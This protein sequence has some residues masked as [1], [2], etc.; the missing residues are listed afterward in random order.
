[1]L[2]FVP[3][4]GAREDDGL[5]VGLAEL[6][7]VGGL[8]EAVVV[9]HEGPHALLDQDD[10]AHGF[11]D[12]PLTVRC[13]VPVDRLIAV[14]GQALDPSLE[15]FSRNAVRLEEDFAIF[16]DARRAGCGVFRPRGLCCPQVCHCH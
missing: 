1:M 10:V 3:P 16:V 4:V 15:R 6:G 11:D 9:R 2:G 12:S 7:F 13:V 5:G 8:E 14:L